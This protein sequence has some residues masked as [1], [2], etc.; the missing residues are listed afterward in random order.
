MGRGHV[1]VHKRVEEY[2]VS[3]QR[4]DA[5]LREALLLHPSCVHRLIERLNEKSNAV[6]V[7]RD[8]SRILGHPHFATKPQDSASLERLV[9]I[10]VGE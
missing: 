2:V 4:A 10:F 5:A 1:L 9:S 7:D 8:W 6:V 3:L